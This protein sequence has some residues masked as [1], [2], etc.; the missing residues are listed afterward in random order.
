MPN[1][2]KDVKTQDVVSMYT[3]QHLSSGEISKLTGMSRT[4]IIKRLNKVGINTSKGRDGPCWVKYNC[5]FCG[6]KIEVRRRSFKMH[7]EHFCNDQCYFASRESPGYHPWRQGQRL[8][9][10]IVSQYV[11]LEEG[12]VI[13]HK[14]G[15]DRNNDKA[16]LMVFENQSDHI[17]F[18]HGKNSVKYLYDGLFPTIP[19]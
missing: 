16:N 1:Q 10:T 17:K 12:N 15:D 2:R 8:A 3:V 11:T 14:D 9:R 19:V 18:H 5:D 7:A 6:K 4:S 13:H